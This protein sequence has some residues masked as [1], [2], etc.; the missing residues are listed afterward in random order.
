[1]RS[2]SATASPASNPSIWARLSANRMTSATRRRALGF[3]A[4]GYP[5]YM[6]LANSVV[7]CVIVARSSR[8]LTSPAVVRAGRASV[9]YP[10]D[11]ARS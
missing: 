7:A 4:V 1:M 8:R 10:E 11:R 5:A 9:S 2:L 3:A 6:L